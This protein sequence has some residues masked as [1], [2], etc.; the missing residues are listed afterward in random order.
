MAA[1]PGNDTSVSPFFGREADVQHLMDRVGFGGVTF[2]AAPPKMG[3]TRLL[4]ALAARLAQTT[5]AEGRRTFLVGC[6]ECRTG[7]DVL[8]YAVQDLYT[9]WLEQASLRQQAA[10]AW[11]DQEGTWLTRAAKAVSGLFG[12]VGPASGGVGTAVEGLMDGL[13]AAN[14]KLKSGGIEAPILDYDQFRD[15]TKLVAGLSGCRIVLILDA[16]DKSQDLGS[17][18]K[19]LSSALDTPEEWRP[20][21]MI[22]GVRH[23]DP[24]GDPEGRVWKAVLG[25]AQLARGDAEVR[26]LGAM[27]LGSDAERGRLL[28]YVRGA[29][30]AAKGVPDADLLQMVNG[31]PGTLSRWTELRDIKTAADLQRAAD[32]A[33]SN[34]YVELAGLLESLDPDQLTLVL[35]LC[36]L[37]RASSTTWPLLRPVVEEGLKPDRWLEC[38]GAGLLVD[39]PL[40]DGDPYPSFGHDTRHQAVAKWFLNPS[41]NCLT[42]LS[43]EA[44]RLVAGLVGRIDFDS[45][46]WPL[47][48][49]ALNGVRRTV[50]PGALKAYARLVA[51]ANEAFAGGNPGAALLALDPWPG[52]PEQRKALAPFFA[53]ALFNSIV[54]VVQARNLELSWK[55]VGLLR[56]LQRDYP[57]VAVI[58]QRLAMSLV[59]VGS[60]TANLGQPD[61]GSEFLEELRELAQGSTRDS[62]IWRE[63]G[64]ALHNRA[65]FALNTNRPDEIDPLLA[66]EKALA[67]V[68]PDPLT[69]HERSDTLNAMFCQ[70]LRLAQPP[71][72]LEAWLAELRDLAMGP[73][74]DPYLREKLVLALREEADVRLAG[75]EWDRFSQ[76]LLEVIQVYSL[77]QDEVVPAEG[78]VILVGKFCYRTDLKDVFTIRLP[79][80]TRV[81]LLR[82]RFPRSRQIADAVAAIRRDLE[83]RIATAPPEQVPDRDEARA[84]LD[85]LLPVPG[86]GA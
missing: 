75:A 7:E 56:A 64:Y 73:A 78:Y 9:Q 63:L 45:P 23:P 70:G 67:P 35:R 76:I 74:G 27:D 17:A 42:R 30:P 50:P 26:E 57:G 3:K 81:Q 4:Q 14:E 1:D 31:Y 47:L 82:R 22:V 65:I 18:R 48:S 24:D 16:W 29:V 55:L 12:A 5:D 33:L 43:L 19:I 44:N 38:I 28:E 39:P 72:R 80:V 60:S 41:H 77:H 85:L 53:R 61:K 6:H 40:S 66:E 8:R 25:I 2:L 34:Q 62:E 52:P 11:K 79:L 15:L 71:E 86:A 36:L 46:D 13:I 68:P 49:S 83:E 10:K 51:A 54:D 37:P 58:R 84:K 20:V 59:N 32:D 21:H 69:L